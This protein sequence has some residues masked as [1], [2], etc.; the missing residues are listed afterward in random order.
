MS[1]NLEGKDSRIGRIYIGG[2]ISV[3][4]LMSHL[5]FRS[6]W[7]QRSC[8]K[9]RA[10]SSTREQ[11][12]PIQTMLTLIMCANCRHRLDKNRFNI[13]LYE[14]H[15]QISMF[16]MITAPFPA[17]LSALHSKYFVQVASGRVSSASYQNRKADAESACSPSNSDKTNKMT[18]TEL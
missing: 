17:C 1:G 6:K 4:F 10:A 11:P 7:F 3:T 13:F 12:A 18:Q 8:S 15:T 16:Y 2:L 9:K 5:E 14:T